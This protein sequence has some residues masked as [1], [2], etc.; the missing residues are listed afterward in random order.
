MMSSVARLSVLVSVV[1]FGVAAARAQD[2][3]P[4]DPAVATG[5]YT[6]DQASRGRDSFENNCSECH[7]SD[8]SGRAGP[9]LKGSVFV[10]R[11][12]GK[13]GADLLDTIRRTMPADRRTVLSE[14]RALDLVAF[15]LQENGF[16]PGDHDLDVDAAGRLRFN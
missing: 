12:R 3:A 1:A 13:S 5:F 16:P 11:W 8:L 10:E 9:P 6:S 7:Q 14:A 15:L 4:R 2:M